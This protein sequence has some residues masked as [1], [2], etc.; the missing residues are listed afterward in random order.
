MM[1]NDLTR[2]KEK[3]WVI[4]DLILT[5]HFETLNIKKEY[6]K[7]RCLICLEKAMR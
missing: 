4:M 5:A 2:R 7:Q 1:F 6:C 3:M